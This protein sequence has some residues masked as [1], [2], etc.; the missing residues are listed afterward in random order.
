VQR[1]IS[2]RD[3]HFKNVRGLLQRLAEADAAVALQSAELDGNGVRVVAR[4]FGEETQAEYLSNL[5]TQVAK[6]KKTVA[7]LARSASGDL[8]F[9]QHS[10]AGKDMNAL[11]KQVLAQFAGKGGGT[12]DFA[13]GKLN[14]PAQ[15]KKAVALAE[16]LVSAG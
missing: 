14:D 2:E 5:A 1:A 4:A 7:L 13:R 9:A 16:R 15:A 6:T 8:I 12:R 11:L 10:S 3:L